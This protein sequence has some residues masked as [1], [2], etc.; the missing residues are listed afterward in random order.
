[1][2]CPVTTHRALFTLSAFAALA[3]SSVVWSQSGVPPIEMTL[4]Q[5]NQG[6]P[7]NFYFL[8]DASEG[9][10]AVCEEVLEALNEPY[11]GKPYA[12]YNEPY[13]KYLLRSRLSPPWVEVPYFLASNNRSSWNFRYARLDLNNDG[14]DEDIL[15]TIMNLHSQPVHGFGISTLGLLPDDLRELRDV[16]LQLLIA[17]EAFVRGNAIRDQI[18]REI[19]KTYS[20]YDISN[21]DRLAVSS[22]F[23]DVVRVDNRHFFLFTNS[24]PEAYAGIR[25]VILFD[26][27]SD[28]SISPACRL[29]SRYRVLN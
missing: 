21:P 22:P 7:A 27:H 23:L 19:H 2:K 5:F 26:V 3:V 9:Y 17:S 16:Q 12:E 14:V 18:S 24:G 13:S 11:P 1:M 4:E 20:E 28:F 29:V 15:N 25:D 10:E 8:A 6:R